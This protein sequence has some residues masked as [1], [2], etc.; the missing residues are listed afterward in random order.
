MYAMMPS[1]DILQTIKHWLNPETLISFGYVALFLIIFAESGLLIGFFF[2]G[3]SL[4]L[5]AGVAAAAGQFNLVILLIGVFIAAF[6]GDQVGY[7]TGK[8]FGR[9]YFNRE[10]SL[11][12]N[13]K[14]VAQS[15]EFFK[16]HGH[17]TIILARFI[18][19]IRTFTPIIAGIGAMPY[20]VFVTYNLIGAFLWGV[21]IALLGY[22]VG[23]L[24]FIEQYLNY[25]IIV[26]IILSL[27]PVITHIWPKKTHLER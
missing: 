10:E 12:F 15:E 24:P 22:F 21:G 16:K 4:L 9:R 1:M 3:D 6:L 19:V 23:N 8:T 5:L 25:V 11:V 17:K 18:P 13:K 2:P 20:S 26:V 7:W 14:H 27:I